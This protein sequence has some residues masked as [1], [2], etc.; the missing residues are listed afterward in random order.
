MET[1]FIL[2][3]LEAPLQSWGFDSKFGRRD[4]LNFPTKSGIL[5]LLCCAMGATGEQVEFLQQLSSLKQTVISYARAKK[6][7]AG[8]LVKIPKEPLLHDFNMIGSGY[9][10]K[11]LW[12]SLLIPKTSEG[13]AAVGGGTKLTHRYYLQDATFAVILEVPA[14]LA[15]SIIS[16][17][18]NPVYDIYLGRKC[19]VPTD[20]VYQGLYS[21]EEESKKAAAQKV[22]SKEQEKILL[23]E[24][25]IV[26]DGEASE[27][28]VFTLNDV[29]VQFGTIKKYSDRRVTV[30]S[31]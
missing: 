10:E 4:T 22:L 7:S 3:W 19:C 5:G 9:D 30:L 21:T 16:A 24:D 8:T 20:F 17:L 13:K 1:K 27:G 15:E 6:N 29:P 2:L 12:Q 11:D 25:F 28:D 23:L 18:Q 26:I 14:S 31:S